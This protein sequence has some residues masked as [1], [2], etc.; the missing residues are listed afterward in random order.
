MP[1]DTLTRDPL[2]RV[3]PGEGKLHVPSVHLPSA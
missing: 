2:C 3:N 1:T